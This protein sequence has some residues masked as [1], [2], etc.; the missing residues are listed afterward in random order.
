MNN[1]IRSVNS[2]VIKVPSLPTHMCAH[3]YPHAY[4]CM[5]K[6]I[7]LQQHNIL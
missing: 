5:H 7:V 6:I 4:M 2:T 1:I 3:T